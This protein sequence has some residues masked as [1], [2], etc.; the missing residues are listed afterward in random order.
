[1]SVI[2]TTLR[3]GPPRLQS[4]VPAVHLLGNGR[5]SVWLTEAGMGRSS[6]LGSALS[7]WTGDRVS[8]ADGWRLWLRD[9]ALGRSWALLQP[10]S[11]RAPG[12]GTVLAGPGLFG[13]VQRDHGIEARVEVCV[14]PEADAELR[15]VTVTN[16]SD[17]V[18]RLDVT[19]CL[20]LV[21]HDAGADASHPAFSKLFVQTA[22][23]SDS[24]ALVATRRPRGADEQHPCVVH[25]LVGPGEFEFETDRARFL[26]RGRSWSRPAGLASPRPLAGTVGNVLDPVFASRRTVTLAP[27]EKQRWTFVL[28][29]GADRAT[30]LATLARFRSE[31]AIDAALSAAPLQTRAALDGAGISPEESETLSRLA[32]AL[33]YGDPRLRADDAVLRRAGDDAAV[34][35]ALGIPGQAPLVVVRASDPAAAAEWD[36]MRRAVAWWRR[37]GID[38]ELVGVGDGLACGAHEVGVR[39]TSTLDASGRDALEAGA[40]IVVSA[41]TAGHLRQPFAEDVERALDRVAPRL[42]GVPRKRGPRREREALL[43]DNGYGG[44]SAD[45]H[46][47]VI[48]LDALRRGSHRRPPM[49]WVNVIANPRFGTLVSESGAGFTWGGNS[50]EHRL[51]PWSN[52]PLLGPH[53]EAL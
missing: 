44:F 13:W 37:H 35:T 42:S 36:R 34:R 39:V 27:G 18:R 26:A 4:A 40:R 8:D 25:A 41:A 28:A 50:R 7:R 21:L 49:P 14:A 15:G 12:H 6:W 9:P 53:G 10:T 23:D 1:M 38:A 2:S 48:R 47:Y 31:A 16:R 20:E 24:S 45:G 46:E 33:L 32:G 52:D 22:L 11:S 29:A 5:Y 17:R 43:Q 3:S 51:T 30:A 19:G